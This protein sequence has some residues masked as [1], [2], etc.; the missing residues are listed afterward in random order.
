[1]ALLFGIVLIVG[2]SVAVAIRRKVPEAL[3][4]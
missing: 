3:N 2:G 1:V 4:V